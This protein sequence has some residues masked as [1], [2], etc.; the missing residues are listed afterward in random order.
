MRLQ[1]ISNPD[2]VLSKAGTIPLTGA[3]EMMYIILQGTLMRYPSE[4]KQQTRERIVRAAARRFRS[5][6]SG[7]VV[8]EDLMRDLHL[9]HGGFYRHFDSKEE[10]FAEAFEHSIEQLGRKVL[11]TIE[12]APR[13]GELK[14]LIDRYLDIEHCNDV[15]SGCPVA[16]LATEI[17]RRPPTARSAFLRV[18]RNHMAKV[19]KY[20]PGATEEERERKAR[21]LFSGMAGTL[22][23]ARVI[24]DDQQR[25]RFLDD[26]KKFYLDAAR[27]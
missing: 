8:I 20:I 17:A 13:G 22:N 21:V 11:A 14:A 7:G 4:H 2:G 3:D 19:A 27:K 26:A 23:L 18:L 15:A 16:A 1:L 25:R 9:T 10:L 24:V 12:Q 6:G 5:R